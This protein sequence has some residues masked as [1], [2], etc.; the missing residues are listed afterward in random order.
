MI[1]G[2]IILIYLFRKHMNIRKLDN[3]YYFAFYWPIFLP[4]TYTQCAKTL[5]AGLTKFHCD[6]VSLGSCRQSLNHIDAAPDITV[7][8]VPTDKGERWPGS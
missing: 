2:F 7:V 6:P 3:S 4:L 1:I 8:N 5:A